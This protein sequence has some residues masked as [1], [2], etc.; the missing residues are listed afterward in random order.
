[1]SAKEGRSAVSCGVGVSIHAN[2]EC[3][4]RKSHREKSWLSSCGATHQ[5][6]LM[7]LLRFFLLLPCSQAAQ[8]VTQRVQI[9]DGEASKFDW[10]SKNLLGL[11]ASSR[12][13][14]QYSTARPQATSIET[15]AAAGGVIFCSSQQRAEDLA[16][17]LDSALAQQVNAKPGT[18]SGTKEPG[19]GDTASRAAA[20]RL[21]KGENS[22]DLK[23]NANQTFKCACSWS[24]HPQEGIARIGF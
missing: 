14:E 1:M 2:V 8:S 18:A 12:N 24:T 5:Y 22:Q 7:K 11:L 20:A 9:V 19:G 21:L 6:S 15:A 23:K 4:D 17:L 16:F 10:L 13:P 3:V